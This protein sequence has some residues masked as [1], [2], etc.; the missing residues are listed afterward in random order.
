VTGLDVPK[1]TSEKLEVFDS[2][3][4]LLRSAKQVNPRFT[5]EPG[6]KPF[7]IEICQM[8][9]GSP[10]AIELASNWL[11]VL[12]LPEVAA[13]IRKSLDFL[14]L[15]QPELAK[16]HRSIRAVF[17][18]SWVR[19]TEEQKLALSK[20]SLLRGGFTVES[21]ARV[22]NAT[23]R[24][25]LGLVSKSL[26][27]RFETRFVMH[28]TVR[29][30]AVQKLEPDQKE[31]ALL[32]LGLLSEK[33]ALAF[34]THDPEK[35]GSETTEQFE[36]EFENVNV[37]LEWAAQ[38]KP[39]LAAQIVYSALDYWFSAAKKPLAITWANRLLELPELRGR[40]ATRANLLSARS[41]IGYRILNPDLRLA[42]AQ[43]ALE[44]ALEIG[45]LAAQAKALHALGEAA[46]DN[47]DTETAISS[48]QKALKI[49]EDVP[50]TKLEAACLN[51]LACA[52]WMHGKL[53]LAC[54]TYE[55]LINKSL[56]TNNKRGL[57]NGYLNSG[58][59]YISLNNLEK[60]T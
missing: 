47:G 38:T 25:L 56:M 33:W 54:Q 2:V 32:E 30:Y 53:D 28:E 13:E 39:Q 60:A 8:L 34:A 57:A 7:V 3:Q 11:R 52:Y 36:Q 44:I 6:D 37:A 1:D 17:D 59:V 27:G 50:N 45:D 14:S 19:L 49:L 51:Q 41:F 10:L 46:G 42:D 4:L 40:D 16:R 35:P 21:A 43:Q 20:L 22:A 26:I 55:D 48:V 9:Q 18:S 15:N 12:N 5:L 23:P 31:A 29:Q 24:L 58:H